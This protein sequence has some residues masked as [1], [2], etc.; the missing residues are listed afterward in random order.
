VLT[1]KIKTDNAAFDENKYGEVARILRNL[2]DKLEG[3]YGGMGVTMNLMDFN[4][5]KVGTIKETNSK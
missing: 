1:I 5:N 3:G 2:A 4:G